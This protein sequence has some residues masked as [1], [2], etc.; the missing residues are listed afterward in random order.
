MALAIVLVINFNLQ[1]AEKRHVSKAGHAP[2]AVRVEHEP[3]FSFGA[4]DSRDARFFETW[5]V[6][7]SK[8]EEHVRMFR[9]FGD[10]GEAA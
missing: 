6:L 9:T 2:F 7:Y 5:G 1:L 3:P 8:M 10:N 4:F